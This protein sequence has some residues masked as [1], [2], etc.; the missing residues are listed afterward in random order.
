ME[1]GDDGTRYLPTNFQHSCSMITP[2]QLLYLY[3]TQHQHH[4]LLLNP[5]L[6]F[7]NINMHNTPPST[8]LQTSTEIFSRGGLPD[9]A[10]LSRP[11]DDVGNMTPIPHKS[12]SRL[13]MSNRSKADLYQLPYQHQWPEPNQHLVKF[14]QQSDMSIGQMVE[15][16]SRSAHMMLIEL[17]MKGSTN[18]TPSSMDTVTV[19]ISN[20]TVLASSALGHDCAWSDSNDMSSRSKKRSFS[21]QTPSKE[22]GVLKHSSA[23]KGYGTT[24]TL[25]YFEKQPSFV[26]GIQHKLQQQQEVDQN[27]QDMSLKSCNLQPQHEMNVRPSLSSSTFSRILN[28]VDEIGIVNSSYS[29]I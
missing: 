23:T 10:T 22:V 20:E 14:H 4:E 11:F 15:Q 13:M 28:R 27:L 24:N 8:R 6:E 29:Y 21:N 9:L 7:T 18:T 19:P 12:D 17:L 26:Y 25:E 5:N 1:D 3:Q 16:N 2:S